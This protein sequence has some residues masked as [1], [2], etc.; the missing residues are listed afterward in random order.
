MIGSPLK[1]RLPRGK[2]GGMTVRVIQM[3]QYGMTQPERNRI[4]KSAILYNSDTLIHSPSRKIDDYHY[5][6]KKQNA[7]SRRRAGIIHSYLRIYLN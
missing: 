2:A 6:Q 3:S 4:Y 1:A 5:H 7:V